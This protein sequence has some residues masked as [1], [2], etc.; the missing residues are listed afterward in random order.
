MSI[1]Q[2]KG[3]YQK[4]AEDKALKDQVAALRGDIDTVYAGM[5]KIARDHGFEITAE[6]IQALYNEDGE[7][8]G[9]ELDSVAG[10]CSSVCTDICG[11][12][13]G[14]WIGRQ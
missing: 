7:L 14:H 3:F 11:L 9:E 1:E 5:V 2:L 12:F 10:G 8:D 4:M 13:M 6:D